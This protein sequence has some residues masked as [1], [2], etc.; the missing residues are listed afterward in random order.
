MIVVNSL[1]TGEIDEPSHLHEHYDEP[2]DALHGFVL[3]TMSI[4]S[5]ERI[6]E[7]LNEKSDI[8]NPEKPDY[9]VT[10]GSIRFDHVTSRGLTINLLDTP[11]LDDINLSI[12]SSE[13]IGI[14][15]GTGSSKSSLSQPNQPSV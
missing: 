4:A 5:A 9:E 1:T 12:A 10:D 8:T 14:I 3:V 7:V 2:H 6:C 15:G 13:T 11:V